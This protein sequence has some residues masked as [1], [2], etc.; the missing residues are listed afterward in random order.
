MDEKPDVQCANCA[1]DLRPENAMMRDGKPYC[2]EFC[3]EQ[4][5]REIPLAAGLHQDGTLHVYVQGEDSGLS[6]G[7]DDDGTLWVRVDE[8]KRA[9]KVATQ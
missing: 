9:M 6:V 1:L 8:S 2:D 5:A 7:L 3:Y 4:A